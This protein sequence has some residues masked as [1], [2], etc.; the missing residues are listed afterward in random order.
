MYMSFIML[1]QLIYSVHYVLWLF[2]EEPI[3]NVWI[4]YYETQSI[5]IWVDVFVFL[6]LAKN[7]D[8]CDVFYLPK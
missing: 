4:K 1:L 7:L 5:A 3:T 8:R 6:F 2:S